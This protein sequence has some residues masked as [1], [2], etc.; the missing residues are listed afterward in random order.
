MTERVRDKRGKREEKE[1]RWEARGRL[2]DGKRRWERRGE[3]AK[4]ESGGK[5]MEGRGMDMGG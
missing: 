1:R 2:D 4:G 5:G 3:R